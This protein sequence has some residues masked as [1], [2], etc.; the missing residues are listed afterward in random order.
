MTL[1]FKARPESG[2]LLCIDHDHDI[3]M[4]TGL[5]LDNYV[6]WAES[7]YLECPIVTS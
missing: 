3:N 1:N 4:N 7:E 5:D 2:T 6:N